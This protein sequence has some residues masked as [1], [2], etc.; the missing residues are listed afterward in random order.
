MIIN[1][2]GSIVLNKI[3]YRS[4]KGK[5]YSEYLHHAIEVEGAIYAK[6][7]T[8]SQGLARSDL[9]EGGAPSKH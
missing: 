7:L 5:F 2:H 6:A 4:H 3:W 1:N 8:G 9:Q